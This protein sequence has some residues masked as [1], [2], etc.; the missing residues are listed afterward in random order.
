MKKASLI[1][2][3]SL[4]STFLFG[5]SQI[6]SLVRAG[7]RYHDAG[8]YEKA[9]ETYKEALKI[10]P[11]SS[12]VN[13]EIGM[14]Y[15]HS[16]DYKKAIKHC[17]IVIKQKEKREYLLLAYI[18]KGSALDDMGKTKESIK[19][20]EEAINEFGNNYLLL[21]NLAV[22]YAKINDYEKA[23]PVLINAIEDNPGHASSHRLLA[24]IKNGQ[25][26]RVQSLLGLYYFL[27]LE[28]VSER[29]KPAFELLKQQLEGS[30]RTEEE[31]G[32][33]KININLDPGHLDSEFSAAELMIAMLGASNNLEANA[34][35]S[36]EELF[37]E[38]TR[39]F[40]AV[41][42][43]LKEKNEGNGLWWDF[44]VP[45][46]YN[47]AKSDYM[48]AFCYYISLSSNK[49]AANWIKSNK[50]KTE[51]FITWFKSYSKLFE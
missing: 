5:Q 37:I 25:N 35:K 17:D 24:V 33:K 27:F 28:P 30:I 16:G 50:E 47:L 41:L 14:T 22:D 11:K 23:E 8:E 38:N 32:R 31:N 48:D 12:L 18:V 9:I 45:L 20:F 51:N 44:Y 46:F 39:S 19:L 2:I 40:F 42:G 4:A 1:L 49:N 34:N 15:S 7:V 13:Y 3:F 26:L 43:E 36:P 21:Y 10:E 29:S 6:D